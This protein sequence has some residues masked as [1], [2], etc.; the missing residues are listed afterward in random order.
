L[1]PGGAHELHHV[2][3]AY[4]A[5]RDPMRQLLLNEKSGRSVAIRHMQNLFSEG[6]AIFYC[7]PNM[8]MEDKVPKSYARKL[9]LYERHG[10]QHCGQIQYCSKP[11]GH[12]IYHCYEKILA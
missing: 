5:E 3:F 4:W 2:G 12:Q 6:L 1:N 11:A 7:S 10:Y 8:V 9:A